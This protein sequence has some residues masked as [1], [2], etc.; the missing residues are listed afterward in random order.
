MEREF[1]CRVQQSGMN[2][3]CT[4]CNAPSFQS[5]ELLTKCPNIQLED[6]PFSTV[7]YAL[8]LLFKLTSMSG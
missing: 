4:V 5:D 1:Q 7:R 8:F 3:A 6:Y 2:I